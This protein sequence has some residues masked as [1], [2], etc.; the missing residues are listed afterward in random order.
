VI[1]VGIDDTDIIGSPGTN[2]LARAIVT[3]LGPAARGAIVCR[4]QLFFDPRIPF[5][6]QNGAASIHLPH[7]DD[8]PREQLLASVRAVMRAWYVEGSDPGLAVAG[9]ASAGMAAFAARAKTDVVNQSEA[10]S[11]ADE[12]RCHLEGL[13]GTNQGIIG[14]LAAIAL[15][16][17]GDDGRVVHVDGWPWPDSFCGVQPV[18][19]VRDRG[20]AEIRTPDGQ[21]FTGDSVDVG[22]HLRPNWRGGRIVMFVEAPSEAGSPWRA[23]KLK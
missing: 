19:A 20:V 13:G 8:V 3:E 15:A 6:S 2:Q 22:K 18:A 11:V 10:R 14:A 4:H 5:T 7:G 23:A 12:A 1:Y 9:E 17:G 16:A 21:V